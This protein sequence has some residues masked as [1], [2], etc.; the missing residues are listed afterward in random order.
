MLKYI[1]KRLIHSIPVI[2]GVTIISFIIIHL[3]PGDFFAS[4]SLNPQISPDLINEMK[5]QF[6]LDRNIF[7]QYILWLKNMFL[8]DFGYSF[9]YKIPVFFLIKSR[10]INTL[11]LSFVTMIFTWCLVIPLGLISAVKKNLWQ[12]RFIGFFSVCF[13]A[14]PSFFLALI[15]ILL[16]SKT[17]FLPIGGMQSL[18]VYGGSFI[19]KIFDIL[20]HVFLPALVL[21][22]VTAG[23][24]IK[25]LRNSALESMSSLYITALKAR[26]INNKRILFTHVLRNAFN[27]MITILGYQLSALLSGAA[28]VEI[29]FSWPGLGRLMLTAVMSKDIY[30]IMANLTISAFLLYAGN[31]I[32]DVCL[33]S[34]DPRIE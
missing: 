16:A 22:L 19:V 30:L 23:P 4:I 5:M 31:L 9:S 21:S 26:G 1:L 32:A 2:L 6:G 18:D 33:K 11:I 24:L 12:D 14:I 29:I 28:F 7:L 3:S 17:S 25:I 27:P 20:K 15:F 10:L 34:L 8:G 13:F